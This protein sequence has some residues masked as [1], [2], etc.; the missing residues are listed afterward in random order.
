MEIDELNDISTDNLATE[1]LDVTNY[2]VSDE[3]DVGENNVD[4]PLSS[5]ARSKKVTK[6]IKIITTTFAIGVTGLLGGT[7]IASLFGIN[8]SSEEEVL[9]TEKNEIKEKEE[10]EES[11][12]IYV[13]SSSVNETK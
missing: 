12:A 1:S 5:Y 8:T 7:M 11:K 4:Y 6:A 2:K 13:I 3:L 10:E 9:K